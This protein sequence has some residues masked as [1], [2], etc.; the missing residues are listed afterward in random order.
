VRPSLPRATPILLMALL[1][2]RA[3]EAGLP[4]ARPGT[5]QDGDKGSGK[6]EVLT[7]DPRLGPGLLAVATGDTVRIDDWP[8]AP[9]LR[10]SVVLARRDVYAPEARIVALVGGREVEV[11]RSR[12]VFFWGTAEGDGT[13]SVLAFIDPDSGVLGGSSASVD[14]S[15][16]LRPPRAG[17]IAYELLP[18]SADGDGPFDCGSDRLPVDPLREKLR[19][20]RAEGVA[21]NL[22][23]SLHSAVI[24]VDTDNELLGNKFADNTTA[25]VNY[26]AQLFAGVN[27][28]Y[29][30]D[31]FVRLQQ[32]YTLLRPSTTPDPY[33]VA[34]SGSAGS[35]QLQEASAYWRDNYPGIRRALVMFLS[36]KQAGGGWSGIAW[37][38]GLCQGYY[39]LS[40]NQVSRSGTTAGGGDFQ[41]VGHE[42]GHN[43]GS[44]HTHCTDT[45]AT[46]GIQPI[47]FCNASECGSS[48]SPNPGASCPAA[49]T[50]TPL[51]GA[52]VTNVRGTIMSYCHLVSGCGV[53]NV[54]HPST[55]SVAIGPDLDAAVGQCVFP[56]AG[57]P[58]P[59]VTAI[60]ATSGGTGGGTAVTITGTNFRSPATVAFGDRLRG[61][62]ATGVTV[63]SAT[64]ITATTPAH[65]AGATDVV[66]MNPDQQ[67]GVLPNGFT[68]VAG[69]SLTAV[70]PN[71]GTTAGGTVVTLTGTGFTAPATV[72]F[73]G[74]AATGVS[75]TSSTTVQATTPAHAAGAVN[76]VFTG[77]GTATLPSG[78]LYLTPPPRSRFYTVTPCRLVDTRTSMPGGRGS[79][80]LIASARRT[81]TLTG[82]CGVPASA[83]ALSV[84]VT[85]TGPAQA[86]FVTLF[87]GNGAPPATST[88]NFG[89]GQTRANSAVVLLAT[90]AT[91]AVAVQNGAPGA[92]HFILDVNG[93]FQ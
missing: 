85:V 41:L 51:N 76:V 59:T 83:L 6:A 25:A 43:F 28:I 52:P 65:A 84:N 77:T 91:G 68:F 92:V 67:T 3:G 45:S 31:M 5:L 54:F 30:R 32:G 66:V 40:Y 39:G 55:L 4:G 18:A 86:G 79:P 72:S 87:P 42:M 81:F 37:I 34:A 88:V 8:V 90:D 14:G 58:P 73:G 74:T 19:Q 71:G 61:V 11:P 10:R 9:G 50:I 89:V 60:A 69:P 26:I 13:T 47:D 24:A 56:V 1:C 78:Y 82:A 57:N 2:A 29:E 63:Q 93:Y 75:V 38:G 7:F 36:G 53:T 22:V 35:A 16:D 27:A 12:L 62:A 70:S 21:R 23:S 48:W 80:A 64:R 15:Y 20:E 46:A 44:P 33:V 17:T 49:A